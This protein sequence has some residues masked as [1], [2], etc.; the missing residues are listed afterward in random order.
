[1]KKKKKLSRMKRIVTEDD[2]TREINK[3]HERL[4]GLYGNKL[5]NITDND[6][7]EWANSLRE[8]STMHVDIPLAVKIA[9]SKIEYQKA[10]IEETE[11]KYVE[12]LMNEKHP[13][14]STYLIRSENG[15]VKLLMTNPLKP[16]TGQEHA[17]CVVMS[18]HRHKDTDYEYRLAEG[19]ALARQIYKQKGTKINP[20]D[21]ARSSK[22]KLADAEKTLLVKHWHGFGIYRSNA[23]CI[24]RCGNID[25]EFV[26]NPETT[27]FY[28][29]SQF[30]KSTHL[31]TVER[32]CNEEAQKKVEEINASLF[33]NYAKNNI[34]PLNE[35][36]QE[37][38]VNQIGK[39]FYQ[40]LVDEFHPSAS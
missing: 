40:T 24:Y 17:D 5:D 20:K 13:S 33:Q 30:P 8:L 26:A 15:I 9:L 31:L 3:L 27:K 29:F 10:Q 14:E 39:L 1:M 19:R 21:Y 12:R 4:T 7:A 23:N 2:I 36:E 25:E 16:L 34:P 37:L 18:Y 35:R 32:F 38:L 6:V 22:M 11:R 28:V